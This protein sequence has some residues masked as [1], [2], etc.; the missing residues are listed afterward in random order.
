MIN[1]QEVIQ[2]FAFDYDADGVHRGYKFRSPLCINTL[3]FDLYRDNW[4]MER[5]L[6]FEVFIIYTFKYGNPF[7]K[8]LEKL[9]TDLR[10]TTYTIRKQREYL[11]DQGYLQKRLSSEKNN[12]KNIYTVDFNEIVENLNNIYKFEIIEDDPGMSFIQ[13]LYERLFYSYRER[14]HNNSYEGAHIF[15]TSSNE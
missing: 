6:V 15:K 4:T 14:T 9:S 3:R 11:I 5:I 13:G 7:Y 8:T 10:M 12:F 2:H 1:N